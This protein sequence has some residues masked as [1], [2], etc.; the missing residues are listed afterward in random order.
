MARDD[1]IVDNNHKNSNYADSESNDNQTKNG[2]SKKIKKTRWLNKMISYGLLYTT[3]EVEIEI[4]EEEYFC[5]FCNLIN[6]HS[7]WIWCKFLFWYWSM[8]REFES[9]HQLVCQMD[10]RDAIYMM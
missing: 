6:Y 9:F 5:V 10:A 3:V 1:I 8:A 7:L 2:K 4:G